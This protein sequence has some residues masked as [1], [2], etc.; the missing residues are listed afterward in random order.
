[1]A[2]P[3]TRRSGDGGR[4]PRPRRR[5]SWA[6]VQADVAGHARMLAGLVILLWTVLAADL[7]LG[8]ALRA[9]GVRPRDPAGLVGVPLHPFLHGGAVHLLLNTF[10][11]VG[12]GGLVLLREERDFW[13][14]TGLGVAVGGLGT[15]LIGSPGVH[16]GASG[17]VF[18]YFGYLLATGWFDRRPGA[19]F[20]S[21]LVFLTWGSLLAGMLPGQQGISWEGHL[22]GFLAGVMTAWLRTRLRSART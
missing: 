8:G 5:D 9:Y 7:L 12:L 15:W 18:A 22:S 14:A 19:V 13:I 20:L 1:M 6:A 3:G 4:G 17:V 11:L 2:K 21:L 16:I 10:G